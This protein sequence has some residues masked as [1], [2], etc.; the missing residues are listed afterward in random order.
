MKRTMI[1]FATAAVL[2]VA[3]NHESAPAKGVTTTGAGVVSNDDAVTRL[4]D[5][6]C[7]RAKA[8]N[9]LGDKEK[10]KD[11]AACRREEK[12]DL[13]ADLR[14]G[15]CPRGIKDEKLQNCIAEIKNEKCGNPFDK[16]SRLATCRTSS[17]CVD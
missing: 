8:C 1:F 5:A 2:V 14:P 17:L 6:R 12:H 16:I 4:T 9:Q 13:Q 15:E 10:Y 7:D 11:D 3:C